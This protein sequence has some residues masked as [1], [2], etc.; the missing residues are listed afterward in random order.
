MN[1][2][3]FLCKLIP[4]LILA[5][6]LAGCQT[7]KKEKTLD[8]YIADLKSDDYL[9]RVAAAKAL[10]EQAG[11]PN[12]NAIPSLLN[13]RKDTNESVR[14]YSAK[15]L[16]NI[17][18]ISAFRPL[19]EFFNDPS[20]YVRYEVVMGLSRYQ[21]PRVKDYFLKALQDDASHVRYAACEGLGKL[22]MK[23]ALPALISALQDPKSSYVRTGAAR[24]IGELGLPAARTNLILA[25]SDSESYVRSAAAE[26][27]GKLGEPG[28]IPYLQKKLDDYNEWVRNSAALA[29][30]WLG[31]KSGIPVLI[32]NLGSELK[33]DK[34]S[35]SEQA[36]N[37]LRTISGQKF[38]FDPKVP[39]QRRQ[40]AISRWQQWWAKQ[41]ATPTPS[42]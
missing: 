8:D 29:L 25:L 4:F 9:T 39:P 35:V 24:A 22:K 19:T 42:A 15:A 1:T 33:D 17:G 5:G 2:K 26:A 21:D 28:A 30:Y 20:S 23:E 27:L 3:Y 7:A 12:V 14:R 41:Q 38:G 31:D 37:Y 18:G 36:V 16:A 32:K 40:E 10:S 34:G 6:F 13:A 11:P